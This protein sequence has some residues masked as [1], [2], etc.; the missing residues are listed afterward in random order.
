MCA[1]P[2]LWW[3]CGE[4]GDAGGRSVAT[5]SPSATETPLPTAETTTTATATATPDTVSE[6]LRVQ[7]TPLCSDATPTFFTQV[8]RLATRTCASTQVT[9]SPGA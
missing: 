1:L 4:P 9:R 2:L 5:S 7:L 8:I 6:A 3:G